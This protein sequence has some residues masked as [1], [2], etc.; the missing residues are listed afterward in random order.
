MA[1]ERLRQSISMLVSKLPG[2][3]FCRA[4]G[5]HGIARGCCSPFAVQKCH[6]KGCSEGK[7]GLLTLPP[8]STEAANGA[9]RKGTWL[10]LHLESRVCVTLNTVLEGKSRTSSEFFLKCLWC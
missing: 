1:G 4:A 2:F 9:A 8:R 10:L 5:W 7:V 3:A 6:V